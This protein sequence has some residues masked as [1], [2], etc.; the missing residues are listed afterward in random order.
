MQSQKL[1]QSMD[2]TWTCIPHKSSHTHHILA[3]SA[4]FPLNFTPIN[5]P[6]QY[7]RK[8]KTIIMYYIWNLLSN[9]MSSP[10]FKKAYTAFKKKFWSL[11]SATW[12]NEKGKLKCCN[13]V[14]QCFKQNTLWS[15]QKVSNHAIWNIE[16]FIEE[17]TRYK[18][19]CAWDN[20]APVPFKVGTLGPHT[21]LPVSISCPVLFSWISSTVWNLFPVKGDF[22]FRKSQN[23]QGT[24]FGL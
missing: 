2:H 7:Q 16:T 5:S 24:K 15:V 18:K 6:L 3:S 12:K 14:L 17:D 22:S 21:V 11:F 13:K 20:D 1:P 23:L 19:H 8:L 9:W 10:A 4:H